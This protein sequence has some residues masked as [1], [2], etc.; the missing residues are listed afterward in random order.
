MELKRGL[1]AKIG[2]RVRLP[3]S[4]DLAEHN[5]LSRAEAL[6]LFTLGAA[7]FTD[8]EADM[9]RIAPGNL[10][11]L[12]LLDRDYF[13]VPND[14]RFCTD[15]CTAANVCRLCILRKRSMARSRL[16]NG[17]SEASTRL[18]SHRSVT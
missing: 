7:W 18:F 6:Q 8:A 16:R 11:D 15:P 14:E 9:G 2:P 17:W 4:E 5:R 1:W 12:A 3:S 10:A 13:T